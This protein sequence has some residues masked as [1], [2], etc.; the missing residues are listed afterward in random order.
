MYAEVIVDITSSEVDRIF[1]YRFSDAQIKIGCRVKVPFGNKI[2]D[3]I[4]I[5][6]TE[7]C[8]YDDAKIKDIISVLD[9]SPAL[10]EESL[11]LVEYMQKRYYC[12]KAAILRLFIPTEMRKGKV[13]EKYQTFAMLSDDFTDDKLNLIKKNAFSQRAILEFLKLNG[14]TKTSVLNEKFGTQALIKLNQ[15]NLVTFITEKFQRSPY[16]N[17][18][19]QDK[20]IILTDA[21]ENACKSVESTLKQITLIHGVTG[22]GK[23]EIYLKLIKNVLERGKTAIML[24]PEIALTPQMLRQLRARFGTNAAILHSGLS[25]GERFDEWWRIRSGEASVVIGARSAI[26]APLE[27]LGIIIIDEEHE[28]SYVSETTPKYET[29]DIAKFRADFNNCKIVLGSATPSIES[30]LHADKGDYNF[31]EIKERINKKPLPE[32]IVADMRREIRSGNNSAISLQLRENIDK[33]LKNGNQAIM[34]LNQRGYSK[35]VVCMDCGEAIKCPNCDVSLT[36]H[37][38]DKSLLCHYCG[39]KFKLPTK[40]PNCNGTHLRFSGTGT[41]KLVLDLQELFP[42]ARILRMD[43]DST[44]NKEGHF[45]IIKDFYEKKADILVGTQMVAKGHDFS[46]V[47]LVGIIDADISLHMSDYRSNERTFQLITQVAGRSGRSEDKG[48]VVLQTYNPNNVVLRQ[49]LRYD[50]KGF[51]K[52]EVSLRKAT[53]F[54]PFNRIVRVLVSASK[55][56]DVK[57]VT[58]NIY[59]EL[60]DYKNQNSDKFRFFGAMKSP[61]VRL[62]N[63]YRYQILMRIEYDFNIIDRI[64]STALKH[65]RRDVTVSVEENPNSLI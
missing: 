46:S 8:L 16:R 31:V 51:Y 60:L 62:Q 29:L 34:F 43:K 42:K 24:V 49:A 7:N 56:E 59:E 13:R 48:I 3:G 38:D 20:N 28:T 65:K 19:E 23:T 37:S 2:I 18:D 6:C 14:K 64:Y 47:T 41:Q 35:C 58:K 1:T 17:L 32:I 15:L 25:A 54:P 5:G 52:N 45:K 61:I 44:Q 11:S 36:Y 30:Y 26:F 57:E 53:A 12:S 27:N 33:C 50:Y 63:K 10:T 22:S 40:C 4:V 21:Q 55:E 39:A 9:D